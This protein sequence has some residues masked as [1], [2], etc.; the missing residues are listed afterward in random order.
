MFKNCAW[1]SLVSALG[2]G[3]EIKGVFGVDVWK[4]QFLRGRPHDFLD[5][6][7]SVLWLDR[8]IEA[9]VSVRDVSDRRETA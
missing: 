1:I 5:D 2:A 6:G 4:P 7:F 3:D 8:A 9:S